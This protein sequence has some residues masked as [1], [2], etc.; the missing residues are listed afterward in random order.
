M[1]VGR[2]RVEVGRAGVEIGQEKRVILLGHGRV[3]VGRT[4]V[5]VR[6]ARVEVGQEKWVTLLS[7]G[8][9]KKALRGGVKACNNL[10]RRSAFLYLEFLARCHPYILLH[11]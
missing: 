2:I 11:F 3:E 4:K 8:R 10:A 6:R 5:E 1:E 7:H 9:Y